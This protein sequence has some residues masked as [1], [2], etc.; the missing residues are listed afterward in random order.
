[1]LDRRWTV[2]S[3]VSLS[4]GLVLKAP[5]LFLFSRVANEF[6]PFFLLQWEMSWLILE[7][8]D[9]VSVAGDYYKINQKTFDNHFNVITVN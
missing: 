6:H 8:L 5:C 4:R 9:A 7:T 2:W 1:M 3:P